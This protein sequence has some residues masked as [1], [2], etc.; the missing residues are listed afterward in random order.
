MRPNVP[1]LLW[2]LALY[3]VSALAQQSASFKLE[4]YALNNGG[5][6]EAG[7]APSSSSFEIA[8]A[9]IGD[10]VQPARVAGPSVSVDGGFGAAYLPP[11]EVMNLQLDSTALSWDAEPSRGDYQVYRGMVNSLSSGYGTVIQADVP[12]ESTIDGDL[13]SVGQAFFYLVTVENRLDHEGTKGYDST[14]SE[15]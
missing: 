8:V 13:P 15:R 12:A 4:E 9:S 14:G 11:G 2:V 3:S 10:G 6:P 7:Q 1:C 5:D